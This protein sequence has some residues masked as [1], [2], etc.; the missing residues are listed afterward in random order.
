[1]INKPLISNF[2]LFSDK[3]GD[4]VYTQIINEYTTLYVWI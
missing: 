3:K 4:Y 2:A 1:M